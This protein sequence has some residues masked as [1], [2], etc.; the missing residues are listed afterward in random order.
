ML[1]ADLRGRA[2]DLIGNEFQRVPPPLRRHNGPEVCRRT[3]SGPRWYAPGPAGRGPDRVG[4]PT[5][6]P[7]PGSSLWNPPGQSFAA[8]HNR[9][10]DRSATSKAHRCGRQMQTP[11]RGPAPAAS[12][13][14][15][16]TEVS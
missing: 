5:W 13:G 16:T 15:A 7:G 2:V 10:S 9:V 14:S 3:D 12:P 11:G 8:P 1:A 4:G 6:A